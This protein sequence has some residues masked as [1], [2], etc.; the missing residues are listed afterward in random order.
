[1]SVDD[2]AQW[3]KRIVIIY[4]YRYVLMP[5]IYIYLL[6]KCLKQIYL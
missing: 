3:K 1:M 2:L 6:I 4:Y 5:Y